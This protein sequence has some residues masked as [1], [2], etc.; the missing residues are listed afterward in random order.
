ML[1]SATTLFELSED[2]KKKCNSLKEIQEWMYRL[3]VACPKG[4]IWKI[5]AKP[6]P[7]SNLNHCLV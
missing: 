1:A 5:V 3:D 6:H 7:N 2:K 4:I